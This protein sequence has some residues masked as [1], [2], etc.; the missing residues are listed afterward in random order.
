MSEITRS[1]GLNTGLGFVVGSSCQ[2][3]TTIKEVGFPPWGIYEGLT[4]E[5]D[6][7]VVKAAKLLEDHYGMDVVI[8]FNTNR[9][10]GGAW[11][12]DSDKETFDSNCSIG[13]SV[14]LYN[15]RL[16]SISADEYVSLSNKERN[17]LRN[18][19]D[20]IGYETGIKLDKT[21]NSVSIDSKD[22]SGNYEWRRF[23]S[24]EAAA[25]YLFAHVKGLKKKMFL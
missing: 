24:L 3:P 18:N 11:I 2:L 10:R 17:E 12:K 13:L 7:Q 6:A 15:S 20:T 25:D 4:K 5:L 23:D 22:I 16:R 19:P 21:E 1:A 14:D 8:R 9:M